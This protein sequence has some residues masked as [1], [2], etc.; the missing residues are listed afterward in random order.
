MQYPIQSGTKFSPPH[1]RRRDRA[2]LREWRQRIANGMTREQAWLE[3]LIS[4]VYGIGKHRG[5]Q[6]AKP[7]DVELTLSRFCERM[8]PEECEAARVEGLGMI[9]SAVPDAARRVAGYVSGAAMEDDPA[10]E[11]I[12]FE[13]SRVVLQAANVLPRPGA[14]GSG[15]LAVQV[16]ATLNVSADALKRALSDPDGAKALEALEVAVREVPEKPVDGDGSG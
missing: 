8:L 15:S 2:R 9:V 6:S 5:A 13:A 16:N 14:G 4:P 7:Y 10:R 11:R 12:R 1:I 3:V